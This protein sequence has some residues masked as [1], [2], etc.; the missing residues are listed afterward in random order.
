MNKI[1]KSTTGASSN[2]RDRIRNFPFFLLTKI[3]CKTPTPQTAS[4]RIGNRAIIPIHPGRLWPSGSKI[5]IAVITRHIIDNMVIETTNDKSCG[6]AIH[7]S[8]LPSTLPFSF[9]VS[10][11]YSSI[12]A[13][14]HSSIPAFQ[15]SSIRHFV[16]SAIAA[17]ICRNRR[18][19]SRARFIITRLNAGRSSRCK[20]RMLRSANA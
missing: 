20:A 19:R 1:E 8:L 4:A 17:S 14:Q 18:L 15:H 9:T 16:L 5:E 6:C 13:F 3:I 11:S 12:P 7:F 10:P 2:T